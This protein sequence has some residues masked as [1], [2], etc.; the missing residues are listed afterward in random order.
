MKQLQKFEDEV[1]SPDNGE[2]YENYAITWD[3]LM[4]KGYKGIEGEIITTIPTKKPP[5]GWPSVSE[6]EYNQYISSDRV[7][8]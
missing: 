4:N 1:F 5:K 2:N 3:V 7:V 8:V 6:S